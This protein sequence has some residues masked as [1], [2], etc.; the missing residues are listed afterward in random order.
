MN[1]IF[2][3]AFICHISIIGYQ[4]RFPSISSFKVYF[5]E[6]HTVEFPLIFKL[7]VRE[8]KNNSD[9][10]KRVGYAEERSF[11]YGSINPE[12]KIIGWNGNANGSAIGTVEGL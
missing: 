10:Y 7:C 12:K 9:R 6:R 1:F 2:F 5:K 3:L 11:Y 8:L 4:L